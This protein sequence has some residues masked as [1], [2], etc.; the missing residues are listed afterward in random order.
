MQERQGRLE[1]GAGRVTAVPAA[2]DHRLCRHAGAAHPHQGE[3]GPAGRFARGQIVCVARVGRLAPWLRPGGLQSDRARAAQGQIE[4]CRH[5]GARLRRCRCR[6]RGSQRDEEGQQEQA[7]TCGNPPHRRSPPAAPSRR[8]PR[9][10]AWALAPHSTPLTPGLDG[11]GF[12]H[13]PAPAVYAPGGARHRLCAWVATSEERA[14]IADNI[15]E[16][17]PVVSELWGRGR[18]AP[19]RGP[20]PRSPR[21]PQAA[22]PDRSASI[23]RCTTLGITTSRPSVSSYPPGW[24]FVRRDRTTYANARSSM[25]GRGRREL[26]M[27]DDVKVRSLIPA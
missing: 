24:S 18:L 8:R 4:G 16:L 13:S 9:L 10:T 17:R 25:H 6:C 15:K 20:R 1:L 19:E 14:M 2:A 7:G 26:V 21:G 5:G 27:T 11:I 3:P 23:S 12:Q 22:A